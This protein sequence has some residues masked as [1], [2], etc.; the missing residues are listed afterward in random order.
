MNGKLHLEGKIELGGGKKRN[1]SQVFQYKEEVVD[2][3]SIRRRIKEEGRGRR[4]WSRRGQEEG[5]MR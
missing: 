3:D 4:R 5:K 1:S 2:R